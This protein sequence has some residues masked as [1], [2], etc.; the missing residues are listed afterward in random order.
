MTNAHLIYNFP[1]NMHDIEYV[2][3]GRR[4]EAPTVAI[5]I[6]LWLVQSS[7]LYIPATNTPTI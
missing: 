2:S 7:T 1:Y 6:E 4:L 5:G 3:D